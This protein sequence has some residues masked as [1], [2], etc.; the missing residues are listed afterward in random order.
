[1]IAIRGKKVDLPETLRPCGC[2]RGSLVWD[3]SW[4]WRCDYQNAAG[5][6]CGVGVTL[7]AMF[8]EPDLELHVSLG[9]DL[10]RLRVS[11]YA[12]SLVARGLLVVSWLTAREARARLTSAG[13]F[14]D[15]HAAFLEM[16]GMMRRTLEPGE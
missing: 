6:R 5:K 4:A 13:A 2:G 7:A 9:R 1:M 11:H 3:G 16:Q 14:E 10:R 8:D 12:L 15:E